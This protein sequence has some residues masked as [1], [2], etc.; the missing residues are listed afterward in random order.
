MKKGIT[1]KYQYIDDKGQT[2]VI[3]GHAVAPFFCSYAG[4]L[5]RSI[6]EDKDKSGFIL[7]ETN[8]I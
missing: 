8:R 2:Q 6:N 5:E 1:F 7:I 4:I 3:T